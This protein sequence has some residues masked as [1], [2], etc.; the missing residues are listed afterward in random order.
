MST[1]LDANTMKGRSGNRN[2]TSG[3]GSSNQGYEGSS[4]SG[5]GDGGIGAGNTTTGHH[6]GHHGG[7]DIV[8]G[9]LPQIWTF[10]A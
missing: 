7:E 5:S 2:I 3:L 4:T 6:H 1:R 9:T 8:H 10:R